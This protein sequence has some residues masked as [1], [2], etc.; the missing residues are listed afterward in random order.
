MELV[1]L[2]Y[3]LYVFLWLFGTFFALLLA[4]MTAMHSAHG[5]ILI[6]A[7]GVLAMVFAWGVFFSI[8]G[9]SNRRSIAIKDDVV[10][11]K[12]TFY[13]SRLLRSEIASAEVVSEA[14]PLKLGR[15]SNGISMPGLRTGWFN[16]A[17]K[18]YLIDATRAAN[19][20]LVTKS[21]SG[22]GLEV[23]DPVAFKRFLDTSNS[24]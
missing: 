16:V 24:H 9:L 12:S 8:A 4:V 2:D 20:V 15:R 13:T 19:I 17:G 1:T 22:I 6:H 10:V 7:A 21:G 14:T 3:R 18:Q 5:H 11:V 23:K